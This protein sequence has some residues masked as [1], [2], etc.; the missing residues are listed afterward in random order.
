MTSYAYDFMNIKEFHDLGIK[1][2]GVKVAVMD[3]GIQKHEDLT[4][5]GGIN[6]FDSSIPYDADINNSHGTKVAGVIASS[7]IGIA[8]E[9]ELYAI[10]IDDGSS[11]VNNT[12]WEEQR[13]GIDWAINNKI[14]ILVCSFS[15]YTE[16]YD[17]MLSFKKAYDNGIAI[18]C[19]AGNKQTGYDTSIDRIGFPSNYP[20]VI[21][22]GN[23][24]ND[25]SRYPS[26]CVGQAV[27]F[28]NGGTSINTTTTDSDNNISNK[29][30]NGTGTSYANPA[31]ASIFALYK[32]MFPN[33]SNNYIINLMHKN[34]EYL[35]DRRHYG[36]GIPKFPTSEFKKITMNR[37][38]WY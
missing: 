38:E 28:S 5:A 16:S 32:Q 29:Y 11:S 3:S 31:T 21:T 9:C 33:R 15:G 18:F 7:Q 27:N 23:I 25:K 36:S 17:R 12:R 4:I 24:R 13:L 2:Q 10:R 35:G 14:D 20:F 37:R 30:S 34:A 26:S 19:S 22:T 8:P 1:G 6:A